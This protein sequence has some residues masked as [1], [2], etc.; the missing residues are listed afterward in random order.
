[1][2]IALG[3]PQRRRCRHSVKPTSRP[4]RPRVCS[5]SMGARPERT[6]RAGVCENLGRVDAPERRRPATGM[7]GLDHRSRWLDR[8]ADGRSSSPAAQDRGARHVLGFQPRQPRWPRSAVRRTSWVKAEARRRCSGAAAPCVLKRS[9]L[10]PLRPAQA[11]VPGSAHCLSVCTA[12]ADVAVGGLV[13]QVDEALCRLSC[14]Q[15]VADE[16]LAAHV[17]ATTGS[18]ITVSSME[19]RMCWPFAGPLTGEQ[20]RGDRLGGGEPGQLVGQDRA[21]QPP[22]APGRALPGSWSGPT[23]PGP[24]DRRPACRH[25]GRARRSR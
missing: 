16:G 7:I 9:V 18:A 8:P 1:M 14:R 2:P 23:A 3:P 24:E 6:C 25:R 4:A 19:R 21:D 12:T 22:D 20:G 17:R 5:P 15:L 10:Q 13:D 11:P